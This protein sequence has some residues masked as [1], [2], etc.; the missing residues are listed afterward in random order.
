MAVAV[1]ILIVTLILVGGGGFVGYRMIAGYSPTVV[2][3][4][5]AG[6]FGLAA[7]SESGHGCLDHG[8]RADYR[9]YRCENDYHHGH[10]PTGTTAASPQVQAFMGVVNGLSGTLTSYKGRLTQIID[11]RS[12]PGAGRSRNR[13]R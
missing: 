13:L 7:A 10:S 11:T 3:A 6:P 9:D 12:T 5:E 8:R 2:T 4:L 1:G